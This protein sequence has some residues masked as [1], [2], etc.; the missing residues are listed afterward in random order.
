[1]TPPFIHPSAIVEAGARIGA[2]CKIWHY[3]HV[4]AGAHLGP[5][6]SLGQGCFVAAGA[7]VGSRCR[8][9]NYV[10]IYAGVTL[11][12]DVFLGPGCVLLNVENPRAP[13]VRHELYSGIEV[14]KGA[15]VGAHATILPGLT[16]GRHSFVAAGA[17]LTRSIPDYAL[18]I[19]VPARQ[20]GFMSR[21]GHRL[22]GTPGQ[23]L[24]CP[25]GH[26]RYR[27][28]D[29]A[30]LHCLDLDEDADLPPFAARLPYRAFAEK[31]QESA[32]EDS[33]E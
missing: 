29:E 31:R 4:E 9:Q 16:L 26:L 30:R 13:V 22:R 6:T 23:V 3:C 10:S 20:D 11:A 15:T 2:G 8:I 14:M 25:E 12:D 17:V 5:G 27:V 18:A 7:T 28:L 19:G 21:H 24:E 32:A 1:M 33:T